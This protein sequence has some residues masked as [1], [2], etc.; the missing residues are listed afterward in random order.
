MHLLKNVALE[1]HVEI[2]IS[3]M[4]FQPGQVIR[5]GGTTRS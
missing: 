5:L 3:K 1:G 2:P 4:G